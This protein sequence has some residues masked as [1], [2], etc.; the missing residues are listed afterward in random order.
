MG[1][2]P[3]VQVGP[4]PR[5]KFQ[6]LGTAALLV[7][8]KLREAIPLSVRRLVQFTDNSISDAELA[9]R[10]IILMHALFKDF[11]GH[12]SFCSGS[13]ILLLA[14]LEARQCPAPAARVA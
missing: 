5:S 8:S 11:R 13:S 3:R 7:A 10:N 1:T 9:V 6:L 2:A 12:S 14:E 4:V